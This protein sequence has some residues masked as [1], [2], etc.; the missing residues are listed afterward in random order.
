M[1]STDW[2]RIVALYDHLLALAPTP[3]AAL[4]RAIAVRERDGP[5]AMLA[6]LDALAEPLD[7]YYLLHSARGD[8]LD[9]LGRRDE[10]R[11]AFEWAMTLTTNAAELE[12][13]RSRRDPAGP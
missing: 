8:A 3:V 13:L 11:A 6:A 1:S 10:A 2:G 12:L 7:G 9:R 4:N 5:A